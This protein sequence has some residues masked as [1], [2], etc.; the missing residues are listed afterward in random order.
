M[1][2][3]IDGAVQIDATVTVGVDDTGY[4][5]KFF[6][7]TSGSSMLWDESADDL[8]LTNAGIA[9]GSDA[10]GDIYYR[11]SNGFLAR[12]AIGSDGQVLTST[13]TVVNWEAAGGG[14]GGDFS[15]PGSATDNAVVRFNGTGGKTGQN[16]GV[17]IDDSPTTPPDLPTSRFRANST[18]PHWTSAATPTSMAPLILMLSILMA[19]CRSTAP[20]L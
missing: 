16:S 7:A 1:L 11:D 6:G 13:G 10:T 15:G 14:G 18:P 12:L 9:V 4:D 3:D 5:V 19:Q 2:V 8:I 17:T 20:S